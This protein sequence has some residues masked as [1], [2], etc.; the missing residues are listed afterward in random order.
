MGAKA[1]RAWRERTKQLFEAIANLAHQRCA[2]HSHGPSA[3]PE[4]LHDGW[5][6]FTSEYGLAVACSADCAQ[7]R[8]DVEFCVEFRPDQTGRSRSHPSDAAPRAGAMKMGGATSSGVQPSFRQSSCRGAAD[9]DT[10]SPA[11]VSRRR[12]DRA[13]WNRQRLDQSKRTRPTSSSVSACNACGRRNKSM[14]FK[15]ASA[16]SAPMP[17]NVPVVP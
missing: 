6:E 9:Q 13:V 2:G 1:M 8:A 11:A 3:Q 7:F 16:R 12:A 17:A 5:A 10:C 14:P 15:L 4:E